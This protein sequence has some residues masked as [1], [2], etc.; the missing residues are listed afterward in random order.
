MKFVTGKHLSL[1]VAVVAIALLTGAIA[2]DDKAL[3]DATKRGDVAAVKSLLKEGADPNV[4][5]GDGLS[6]LHLAAQEGDLEIAKELLGAGAKVT[7]K[8]RI[9][10]Y[11]P[12]HLASGS[13]H[14]AVVRALIAAGADPGAVSTTS[15]VTPLH[16]AA[17]ALNGEGAVRALLEG[18]APANA[19]ESAAR[20]DGAD[21]RGFLW[22]RGVGP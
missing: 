2:P 12:L 10:D 3:L 1:S 8:T 22:P 13:A 17:K 5:R 14:A 11:T 4:S 20:A 21:V 16:L 19:Q 6:A 9:G 18:G 7:A 15:G